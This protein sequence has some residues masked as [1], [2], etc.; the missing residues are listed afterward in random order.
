MLNLL[1][2]VVNLFKSLTVTKHLVILLTKIQL[3]DTNLL[4][5]NLVALEWV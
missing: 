3:K 2:I 4:A 1:K 5:N